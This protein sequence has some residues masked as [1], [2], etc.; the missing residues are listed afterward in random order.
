MRPFILFG[1]LTAACGFDAGGLG[2]STDAADAPSTASTARSEGGGG[3]A[4]AQPI[5]DA[6]HSDAGDAPGA[7]A[8]G[9]DTGALDAPGTDGLLPATDGG[10]DAASDGPSAA[11]GAPSCANTPSGWTVA[12]YDLNSNTNPCPPS[13][14]AH[15][16]SGPPTV[17]STACSCTCSVTQAASCT[18]GTLSVTSG[19]AGGPCNGTTWSKALTGP[20]CTVLG[21][22]FSLTV[23]GPHN[24][25]ATPLA[26]QGGACTDMVQ[27]D[28][29]RV[30]APA[31][32][33]CDVPAANADS[34][35]N[36][37]VPSGFAAC[38]AKSGETTCPSGTPFM[39]SYVVEDSVM[40][41]CAPCSACTL[42]TTCSNI[43]LQGFRDSMCKARIGSVAVDGG[44][45]TVALDNYPANF[46][47]LEYTA[48]ASSTCTPGS[49]TPT[50]QLTNPRTICCR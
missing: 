2:A 35:C 18:Q 41:Q 39:H 29:A 19:S 12:I 42:M 49:S 14:T 44:C 46:V 17:G 25:Q 40:L 22:S 21:P 48:T 5:A 9:V 43:I 36:G 7:N 28:P 26:P 45:N 6:N 37:T 34:V 3:G 31:A 4:D 8:N 1:L 33:Y 50:P 11:D 27:T 47:A 13:F 24:D 38:I 10:G 15:D 20:G 32:R 30:S 16:V 23:T